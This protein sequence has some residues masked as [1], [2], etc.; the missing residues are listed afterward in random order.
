MRKTNNMTNTR[1]DSTI[2]KLSDTVEM[3]IVANHGEDTVT[4][5]M[6]DL[7]SNMIDLQATIP[8]QEVTQVISAFRDIWISLDA[9]RCKPTG[10][11]VVCPPPIC[12]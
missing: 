4:I 3:E 2:L 10:E 12:Q 7:I 8:E 5:I 6:R 11:Q 1:I 9:E